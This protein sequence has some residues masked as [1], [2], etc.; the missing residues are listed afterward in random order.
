MW[1]VYNG[2]VCIMVRGIASGAYYY[3][4]KKD[5]NS[6]TESEKGLYRIV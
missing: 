6:M 3:F 2:H 4:N 5:W 1:V